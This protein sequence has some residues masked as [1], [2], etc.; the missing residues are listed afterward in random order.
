M[1]GAMPQQIARLAILFALLGSLLFVARRYLVPK[2]FGDLGHYRAS[3]VDDNAYRP[4]VYAGHDVCNTCHSEIVEKA[5]CLK[6]AVCR[7][8]CESSCARLNR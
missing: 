4:L 7:I 5:S 6:I 8:L 3:A 2:S 1:G